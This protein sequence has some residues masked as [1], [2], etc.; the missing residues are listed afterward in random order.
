[1]KDAKRFV[2]NADA[3][4]RP[5]DRLTK[6]HDRRADPHGKLWDNEEEGR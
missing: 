6:Y 3:V 1:V 4:S 2:F 5:S